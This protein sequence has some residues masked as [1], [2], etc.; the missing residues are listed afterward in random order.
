MEEITDKL[1]IIKIKNLN[2]A[3]NNV[4]KMRKQDTDWKKIF[5][6]DTSDKEPLSKIYVQRTQIIIKQD[7]D[8]NR[9]LTKEDIQIANKHKHIKRCFH[10]GS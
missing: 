10:H 4:K 1:D 2:S 8:L 6:I 7:K 3:K 9:Q 5:A